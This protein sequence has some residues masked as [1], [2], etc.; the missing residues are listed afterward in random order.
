MHSLAELKSVQKAEYILALFYRQ[1]KWRFSEA[2]GTLSKCKGDWTRTQ[3]PRT[4]NFALPIFSYLRLQEG[5]SK[6][7]LAIIYFIQ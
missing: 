3:V 4:W 6:G 5:P 1:E 2:N 7:L